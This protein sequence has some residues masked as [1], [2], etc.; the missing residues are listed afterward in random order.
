V[1]AVNDFFAM[2]SWGKAQKVRLGFYCADPRWTRAGLKQLAL[3]NLTT[4]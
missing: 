4:H 1:L 2:K 3:S